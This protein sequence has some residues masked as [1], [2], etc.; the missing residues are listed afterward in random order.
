MRLGTLVALGF[1]TASSAVQVAPPVE[2]PLSLIAPQSPYDVHI[3][4]ERARGG[5]P[6]DW[7]DDSISNSRRNN[8]IDYQGNLEATTYSPGRAPAIPLAVRSPYVSAWSS[9]ANGDLLNSQF[10]IFWDGS[11]LGWEG[12]VTVD[13][14]SY[15][16]MGV[17]S[18]DLPPLPNL[19]SAIPISISYDSS[20]S[21]FTFAAGPVELTANFFSPVTPQDLCRTSI[22][23]SYL[24][25]SVASKDGITHKVSLY[26]DV[27]GGWVTQPPAPLTWQIYADGNTIDTSNLTTQP[28]TLYTWAVQLRDQFVFGENYGRG[29]GVFPQWGDFVW[30]SSQGMA[31]SMSFQS[32]YSVGQRF[33]YVTGHALYNTVDPEFRP[34]T[35]HE[36]VFALQHDLGGIPAN[37]STDSIV[38]TIGH[39]TNPSIQFLSPEGIESLEPWWSFCYGSN[40]I[41][42]VEFHYKDLASAK[43]LANQF[44]DKLKDDIAKYYSS[45]TPP[46]RSSGPQDE[47]VEQSNND[48][49]LGSTESHTCSVQTTHTDT[50]HYKA[51]IPVPS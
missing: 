13:D 50:S 25:V 24:S 22:P 28:D 30:S 27:N 21:N 29:Q 15:E 37:T 45:Q 1:V 6:Q 47:S 2:S 42:L 11:I 8:A 39:I 14:I 49:V 44:E 20:Y 51:T 19:M 33:G 10:P 12:I 5:Q 23:L 34:Y 36:P 31:E 17:G 48:T 7:S 43:Q 35:E 18:R 46:P 38:F 32:G 9:T 4:V 3:P 40:I 16:W 41:D 26:T